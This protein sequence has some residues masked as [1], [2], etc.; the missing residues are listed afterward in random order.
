MGGDSGSRVRFPSLEL[1]ATHNQR[2]FAD[3]GRP[4]NG[5]ELT[6]AGA[7]FGQSLNYDVIRIAHTIVIG[8]D[9][10][11]YTFGNTIRIPTTAI[12]SSATLIHELTHVWQYQT[13]GA[14]YISDSAYHQVTQGTAAYAVTIVPNQSLSK[15]TAEQQA[16]IVQ[17]YFSNDPAGWNKDPD[18]VRMICEVRSAR[19][20][21]QE[22]IDRDIL[23]IP[24]NDQYN[25]PDAPGT[26]SLPSVTPLI[27][28][29][30]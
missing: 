29:E 27:R 1:W 10:L 25:V 17:R 28:W 3:E 26:G 18:V 5:T 12:I 9:T 16:V 7:V 8:R 14:A 19:P 11:A 23:G 24:Q 20:I 21:S 13:M 30:W 4:L 6:M 2:I 22:A 15:Y